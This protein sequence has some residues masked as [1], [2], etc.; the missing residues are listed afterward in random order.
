MQNNRNKLRKGNTAKAYIQAGV[1]VFILVFAFAVYASY[2]WLCYASDNGLS[3]DNFSTGTLMGAMNYIAAPIFSVPLN[4]DTFITIL[5]MQVTKLWWIY[6]GIALIIWLSVTSRKGNEYSG[7]EKGSAEWADKYAEQEF[8]DDTGIPQGNNFYSTVENANKKSYKPHNLNEVVIGGSGAGK[9]FRKI[10]PDIIQMFGSYVVTDPKGELYR[11]T[12]KLLKKNGYNVRVLNLISINMTNTYNPFVYMREEQDVVSVADLFMKNTAGEG[13]KEDFWSNSAKDLL[14]A[15]MIYLWKSPIEVKCFGRAVRL[16]N[17]IQYKDGKVD[18][19][20]ELSQC[21]KKHQI[22][23]PMDAASVNWES[24]KGTPEQT[25][26]GIAKSLSSRL[27]LWAV[28]DVDLLTADDEMDFDSVGTEKTAIF[29]IIPPARN[30]Y[31]AI[32][33]IFYSQ[34]FERLMYCANFKH[35][36]RLPMLVSCELDEF[37]NIGKIP[38]FNE[39][40]SVVRSHN[41]RICI[42]LQ[43]LSQ[44]KA[45]YEKTWESIIGNCSLFTYL[46]T[47]DMDT[48]EYVVK[49]L[50]KTTVRSE[51]KSHNR[52]NQ[53]G[54]STSEHFDTRDL[55][56]VEELPL[57]IRPKG[58]SKK[59][60]GNCILFVDEYRPFYVYK[61]DTL[62]HPLIGEVGSSFD[63][64]FHNNTDI[65]VEYADKSVKKAERT[66]TKIE[67][68][69]TQREE[70]ETA[71]SNEQIAEQLNLRQ[72]YE[73]E[74]TDG[75]FDEH[76]KSE[77]AAENAATVSEISDNERLLESEF[78]SE[79]SDTGDDFDSIDT[80]AAFG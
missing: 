24:V 62:K 63:K 68:L 27:G 79:F 55:V 35:N 5:A 64:D 40:L 43:G 47:N 42:V 54:G 25:M 50:G 14:I 4:L 22:E 20:C 73:L 10:K 70:L 11:D 19:K 49:K 77:K 60:G 8:R 13:D 44:L 48:K 69:M 41:I 38:N 65:S 32:V 31:K 17:S 59:Y 39:T 72:A 75:D 51:T 23:H 30:P 74:F 67:L 12:A 16:V 61:Y 6:I 36:G 33:N 66:A 18:E 9:S 71:V 76:D 7:I 29:L 80:A 45:L 37:A 28:E 26:G 1:I 78:N 57:I 58:K 15:I 56:T 2:C 3:A 21:M 53:G 34:L 46:G 52:G